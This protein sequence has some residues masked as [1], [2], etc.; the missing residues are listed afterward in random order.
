MLMDISKERLQKGTKMEV[1]RPLTY[2]KE[3]EDQLL[4]W[5]LENYYLHLQIAILYCKQKY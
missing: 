2:S 3:M 4:V 5:V 1:G